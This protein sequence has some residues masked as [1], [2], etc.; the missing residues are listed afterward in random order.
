MKTLFLFL[1]FLSFLGFSQSNIPQYLFTFEDTTHAY[2]LYRD[3]VSNPNC[4]WQIGAPQKSVFTSSASAP[5]SIVTD[6]V[7][8]Y[9]INDTSS[10]IIKH[11][12][13]WGYLLYD[14]IFSQ[15]SL[16]GRYYV[17]TDSLNDFGKIEFSPDNGQ[18]WILIS[19]DTTNVSG[20]SWPQY[21]GEVTL[22]GNSGS[23]RYFE[24]NLKNNQNLAFN[25][26]DTV[27][28]KF[29]FISDSNSDNLD[30]LMF[31]DISIWDTTWEGVK[32]ISSKKKN[33]F[34]NPFSNQLTLNVTNET[35][36]IV[37]YNVNGKVVYANQNLNA[38][39]LIIDTSN[40][41][42]GIYFYILSDQNG[43]T[44]ESGKLVK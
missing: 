36:H 23:W 2:F 21:S 20:S 30:G 8:P 15:L 22:T 19:E 25:N 33:V 24:I 5:N 40:F 17:N 3:T 1:A 27:Q 44:L 13:G 35:K 7:N 41:N 29:T 10:F 9:P 26:S 18:S 4:I 34:P 37:I 28:Y 39:S 38:T 12:V 31:D 11:E 42:E 14:E 32:D 16:S 6:T 43:V